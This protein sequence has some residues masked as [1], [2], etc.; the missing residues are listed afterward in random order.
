M[1]THLIT[2]TNENTTTCGITVTE[3]MSVSHAEDKVTC[4]RCLKAL[5]RATQPPVTPATLQEVPAKPKVPTKAKTLHYHDGNAHPEAG[6]L[7]NIPGAITTDIN[8]VTCKV[9]LAKL[10]HTP[11]TNA[12]PD[13][14]KAAR[15]AYR[16][17]IARATYMTH[18]DAGC[19]SVDWSVSYENLTGTLL[20]VCT[21]PGG[22]VLSENG[23]VKATCIDTKAALIQAIEDISWSCGEDK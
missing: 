16:S 3:K 18:L 15:K 20:G 4:K 21:E 11:P 7:C 13:E 5:E 6:T 22:Y 1:T 9:C 23:E 2:T 14:V 8:A 12:V 17:F 10:N 19:G